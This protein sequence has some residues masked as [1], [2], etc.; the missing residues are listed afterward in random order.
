MSDE[1]TVMESLRGFII[2]HM[3]DYTEASVL[4]DFPEPSNMPKNRMIY[5]VP[6]SSEYEPLTSLEDIVTASYSLYLMAKGD[7]R[8]NMYKQLYR[9]KESLVESLRSNQTLDD[10]ATDAISVDGV[11]FFPSVAPTGNQPALEVSITC[12]YVKAHD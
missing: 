3:E 8:E 6:S 5:I 10:G 1:Y 12:Q 11:E 9:D 7:R 4:I 2:A